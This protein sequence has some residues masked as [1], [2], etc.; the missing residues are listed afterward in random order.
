MRTAIYELQKALY[1]RLSN[2]PALMATVNGVFD[3]ELPEGGEGEEA[4]IVDMPYIVI[5][6]ETVNDYSTKTSDGEE[7]TK[8]IHV[9]SDYQG[10]KEAAD[11]IDLML[12]AISSAPLSY[13]AGFKFEGARRDF[14]EVI[15]EPECFHG[16]V[17]IR[18]RITQI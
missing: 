12:Q 10:R 11:I 4:V 2:D 9:Y 6:E 17:R 7:L 18:C 14:I 8:T 15:K 1:Q 16:V 13:S 5:G 3:G